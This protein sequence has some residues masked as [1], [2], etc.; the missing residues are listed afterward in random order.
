[1]QVD[2]AIRLMNDRE[3]LPR[4]QSTLLHASRDAVTR[5]VTVAFDPPVTRWA[6]ARE[7]IKR[8]V[9]ACIG[10][11]FSHGRCVGDYA[12]AYIHYA[13]DVNERAHVD[14]FA[15]AYAFMQDGRCMAVLVHHD[16]WDQAWDVV[17]CG[18]S[19]YATSGME[20]FMPMIQAIDEF[21]A[22][23]TEE[24]AAVP[25]DS[26]I[27]RLAKNLRHLRAPG[28]FRLTSTL[29]AYATIALRPHVGDW[30]S[31]PDEEV[32]TDTMFVLRSTE[33]PAGFFDGPPVR[34]DAAISDEL[35]PGTLMY[36]RR[37]GN[38]DVT[39]AFDPP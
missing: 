38:G 27:L 2:A 10:A 23:F 16:A 13:R 5:V 1:M 19:G 29:V 12:D 8:H 6:G 34:V 33:R 24:G 15:G 7:K 22:S 36:T 11:A 39:V 25:D 3:A 28:F 20:F 30:F 35:H 9:R 37:D 26:F 18:P 21:T 32:Y 14:M 17:A 31:R 4:W